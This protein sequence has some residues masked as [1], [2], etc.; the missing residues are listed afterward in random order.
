MTWASKT[1]C[2]YSTPQNPSHCL[3]E[4]LCWIPLPG[5]TFTAA[6]LFQ[7]TNAKDGQRCMFCDTFHCQTK[8]DDCFFL[9]FHLE[10]FPW[11]LCLSL[12]NTS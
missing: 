9:F 3:T 11:Q 7:I 4:Q 10:E 1:G 2:P 8:L 12:V 5:P 6:S